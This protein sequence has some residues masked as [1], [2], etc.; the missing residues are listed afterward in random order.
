MKSPINIL[1]QAG[2]FTP[3]H[4]SV[5]NICQIVAESQVEN[6]PLLPGI[7]IQS[8]QCITNLE[9]NHAKNI[10]LDVL[11]KY[12]KNSA[13]S[14]R[15]SQSVALTALHW[16]GLTERERSNLVEVQLL[17]GVIN[18]PALPLPQLV[19]WAAPPPQLSPSRQAPLMWPNYDLSLQVQFIRSPNLVSVSF[20]AACEWSMIAPGTGAIMEILFHLNF[21]S[22]SNFT[23]TS[24]SVHLF[25]IGDQKTLP[26]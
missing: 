13:H 22:S 10:F 2:D 19:T 14:V 7:Q 16:A 3:V 12:C 15:Q 11:P 18:P 26:I 17:I 24:I 9:A 8:K 23:L 6:H 5:R 21:V 20:T 25:P 1:L 4:F